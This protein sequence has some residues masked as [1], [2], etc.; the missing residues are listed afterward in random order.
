MADGNAQFLAHLPQRNFGSEDLEQ[1]GLAPPARI[2]GNARA[3]RFQVFD[4]I[5]PKL[6]IVTVT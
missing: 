2:A 6:E 3:Q 5:V 4:V 1:L